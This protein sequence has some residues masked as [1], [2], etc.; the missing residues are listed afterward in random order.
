MCHFNLMGPKQCM[1]IYF[2]TERMSLNTYLGK[3]Y[4]YIVQINDTIKIIFTIFFT[5]LTYLYKK[6]YI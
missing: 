5:N 2:C 3:L 6:N 1:H 4:K